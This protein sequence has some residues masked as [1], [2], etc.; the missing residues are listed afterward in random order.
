[1]RRRLKDQNVANPTNLVMHAVPEAG[2]VVLPITKAMVVKVAVSGTDLVLLL[3]D[4]TQHVLR[5]FA[6]R[7]LTQPNLRV[8][9][10]DVAVTAAELFGNVGKVAF[11]QLAAQLSLNATSE[12]L[13]VPVLSPAPRPP[14]QQDD[15]PAPASATAAS[16]ADPSLPA[17]PAPPGLADLQVP[18]TREATFKEDNP[19]ATPQYFTGKFS[20]P[21]SASGPIGV[22]PPPPPPADTISLS[23]SWHN[24]TGQVTG[25]QEG[26][27][28]ITGSGGSERSATDYSSEAQAEREIIMGTAGDDVIVG[29]STAQLGTGFARVLD[30]QLSARAALDVKSLTISGLPT[31]FTVVGATVEGSGWKVTLPAD[32]AATGYRVSLTLQ[33]AVASDGTVFTPSLL[34]LSLAASG[35]MLGK[36]ITGTR[37]I[38]GVLRDVTSSTD[39]EYSLAGKDGIVFPAFGLGDEIYAGA[40]ND[41]VRAGVGHDVVHGD[42]GNDNLDGGAGNDVL[43]GGDGADVL[44]GG[45]GVDTAA[46]ASS[47]AGVAVDLARGTATGGQAEGDTLTS[48]ENLTGSYHADTL[49]GDSAANQLLGAEGDDT[50]EGRGGA[51][52]LDGG[53]GFDRADY[54]ASASAVTINLATGT[55]QG[56][57]AEGDRLVGIESVVGG[58]GNDRLTGDALDNQLQGGAGNDTLEGAA[59]ADA[60]DGGAG[61][62]LAT[63]AGAGAAVVVSLDTGTGTA[64][65]ALG[66]TLQDIENLTGSRF[67]DELTGNALANTLS[68]GQGDDLLEGGAGADTLIG[69]DGR[70]TASY[71]QAAQGVVVSLENPTTNTGDALGDTFQGIENLEG[72]EFD[73]VLTGDAQANWLYGGPGDDMLYGKAGNDL[74]F[75]GVG[76]DTLDGGD[77]N[78]TAVY[79][80]SS[81]AVNANLAQNRGQGGD[82]EGDTYNAV[83]N[84]TGSRYADTLV[85]DAANNTLD[86]GRGNDTLA[87]GAG[88]DVLQG[89]DGSDTADYS[90]S[91]SAVRIDMTAAVY[92]GGD[93]VGDKLESIENITGTAFADRLVGSAGANTLAGGGADDVLEG[94]AG[95]DNLQGG[96]G[97][98]LLLGGQG[99]D[100]L[101][102]GAGSDTASYAGTADGVIADLVTG[103]GR[104]GEAEG[105]AYSGIEN[106]VGSDGDDVLSGTADAN[107]LAGG[108]GNDTLEGGAG[109]DTLDGGEGLDT[110][111][112]ARAGSGIN[113]NLA[114]PAQGNGDATGDRYTSIENLLGSAFADVLRGDA[115]A[116]RLDGA[117]GDDLL[118][119]GAGGDTLVGGEGVDTADYGASAAAVQ[120]D[121]ETTTAQSGGD[122]EGDLLQGLESLLGTRFA[123]TL[124]GDAADN[125]LVG[126]AGN[127]L[128]EGRAGADALE[129]GDGTDTASYAS[130]S[131][132]VTANLAN[133]AQNTGDAAGDTFTDIENLAGGAF[134]DNLTGDASDNRLEGGDGDDTLQGGVGADALLGGLGADTASYAAAAAG[135]VISLAAPDTNTGEAAG[136]TYTSIENLRGSAFD[137]SITGNDSANKLFGGTGADFLIGNGGAD[138]LDGGVGTDTASYAA[139]RSGV[140]VNL[141]TGQGSG[142]DAQG[143]RLINVENL[144]GSAF[145]DTLTGNSL[146]NR[147]EGGEGN[148]VLDGGLGADVLR[149]GL[150]DDTYGVDNDADSVAEAAGEGTDTVRASVSYALGANLED[151]VLVGTDDIDGTGNAVANQLTGN[152]GNNR[153]D[154]GAGADTLAGGAGDDTYVVDST[155]DLTLED[156]GAGTDTVISSITWR[157]G[158]SIENLI[159]TGNADLN[160]TGNVLANSLTGNSGNNRLDGGTGADRMAGGAGD[161][162]YL[163]DNVGD[164]VSELAGEGYDLVR[165]G[166]NHT[167][168]ANVEALELTGTGNFNA[169]GNSGNNAL[170]GNSGNN[171]LDGG[172]GIDRMTGGAGND[173]YVVD[174]ALDLTVEAAGEGTDTVEA[175]R[176]WT[177]GANLENLLLTGTDDLDGTGNALDNQ[178]IGNDG[179]NL[180]DGAAGA[181]SMEGGA[182]NDTY[183]VD[184]TDDLV[185]EDAG[186]GTDTVRTSVS[187]GLTANVENL[188]LAGN[189]AINGT[190]NDANNQITGNAANNRLDGGRGADRLVGGAGDDTYVVD[191]AADVLL[192]LDAEG[193]DTVRTSVS[194]QLGSNFETLVL[195]GNSAI[196]GTGNELGNLLLGNGGNNVL[197]GGLGADSMVGG[198]G[199]DTYVVDNALDSI[200]EAAGEGTDT[201]RT[202]RSYVLGDHLDN[203]VL[204]GTAQVNGNGNAL[205]NVITGNSAAN[206]LDGGEGADVLI[207]GDGDDIYWVDHV[208]DQVVETTSLAGGVDTVNATVSTLLGQNV[209]RLNLLGSDAIDGSGNELNNT[210]VGNASSNVLDGGAGD[211][212]MTG[213]GGDDTY[214]VDSLGDVVTEAVGAGIDTVRTQLSYVLGANFENLELIGSDTANLTGNTLDNVLTGNSANNVIDGLAGAD[215]MVGGAGDDT[216]GVDNVGD[217]V[218]EQFDEG[219]D[220]VRSTVSYGLAA[221]VEN[222]LLLGAV[223]INATGN[224]LN[225][226]LTGN[227]GANV[228]DGGLGADAMVGGR[229]DDTYIVDNLGDQL[230]EAAAEGRDTVR[231]SVSWA[232]GNNFEDLV[233]TGT[234]NIDATGNLAANT[235]TG[236]AGLNTINGGGGADTINAGAGN[237]TIYV[238]DMA[239]NTVDGGAG[240]DTL[241]LNGAG[242]T[243][244]AGLI[245]KAS[246]I[247]VLDFTGGLTDVVEIRAAHVASP[248]LLGAEANGKLEIVLDGPTAG[249]DALIL[250]ASE[251]NN[252]TSVDNAPAVFLS[253]GNAGRLLTAVAPGGI[254]LAIDFGTL[255]LPPPTELTTIWGR[256]ADPS[257]V[258]GISGLA[259]WL[260]ATDLDGDG[261][262]EGLNEAGITSGAGNLAVWADKSGRGNNFTQSADATARPSL[263]T[264]GG[265][266]G[267][268]TVRFDGGDTLL[269]GTTFAQSYTVFVVGAMEGSQNGRLVASTNTNELIGWWGGS[270]NNF[271][272]AGWVTVLQTPIVAGAATMFTATGANGSGYLWNNGNRLPQAYAGVQTNEDLGNLQLGAAFGNN[273]SEASKADLSEVLV[274]DHALTDGERRVVESYLRTKWGVGA[275]TAPTPVGVMGTIALD[276]TWTA[277]KLLY[278][279]TGNDTLNVGYTAAAPRGTGRVDAVVFGGADNDTL[280]GGDRVDALYGGDGN[281]VLNGGLGA[282][283]LAGGAGDDTYTVDSLDDTVVEEAGA[284]TDT[285]NS[286][287]SYALAGNIENLTLTGAANSD[288]TGNNLAN[289]ITGNAGNNRIDGGLGADTMIGGDGNDTYTVDNLGDV[290]IDSSGSDTIRTALPGYVMQAGLENLQLIGTADLS[291]TANAS[292]NWVSVSSYGGKATVYG[293]AGD[294]TYAIGQDFQGLARYDHVFVENPG[295]GNDTVVIYRNNPSTGYVTYTAPSNIE[296][297]NVQSTFYVN[298]VGSAD[299]NVLTGSAYYYTG[300]GNLHSLSGGLGNDAYRVYVP[301][302]QVIENAGEGVDTIEAAV[303]F[304]LAANVENGVA[305]DL[306]NNI[307]NRI[308]LLGNTQNNTLT[309]NWSNNRLNGGLGDDT[310]VGGKGDDTFV[311]DSLGDVISDTLGVDTVETSLANYTLPSAFEKLIFTTAGVGHSGTGNAS[312]NT[313]VGNTANDT[314]LGNDGDDVLIGS[315]AGGDGGT[316]NLAGGNGNDLLIAQNTSLRGALQQGLRA[317]YFNNTSWAGQP[318]LVRFENVNMDTGASPGPGIGADNFSVRFTGDLRAD[319]TGT[320]TFRL[321]SDDYGRVWIDDQLVI[322]NGYGTADSMTIALA[323]GQHKIVVMGYEGGG[324]ASAVLS[325]QTPGSTSFDVVPVTHLSYGDAPSADTGGD[326][327]DGGAGDDW[328][329]GGAAADTL[330]GGAGNDT[331]IVSNTADTLVELA[332]GGTDTV[333]SSASYS[334]AGTQLENLQLT[335]AAAIDGTGSMANNV[336]R[337]NAAANV[338]TGDG[339]ND[340]LMGGGGADTLYGGAGNDTLSASGGSLLDGGDDNDTLSLVSLWTPDALAGKA[341]WLDAA[342]IDGDGI[343][344]GYGEAGLN[345]GNQVQVWRDKSGL[346]RDAIQTDPDTQPLLVM[347]A[348]NGQASVKFDGMG[349]VITALGL[350]TLTGNTN[351]LFWVQNTNKTYYMPMH[352]GA[353]GAGS[354]NLI[355]NNGDGR[356][357]LTG[358]GN[359]H[360]AASFGLDGATA[361]FANAGDAY[362]KLH[363]GTH[364]VSNLNQPFAWNGQLTLAGGYQGTSLDGNDNMLAWNFAGHIPE[365]LVTTQTLGLADQQRVEGYLAWKWG[366]QNFLPASHP[367]KNAA[368]TLAAASGG[369]LLGGNGNDSLT[370]GSGND[371]LDGGAGTDVMAG[372]LGNDTYT[373]DTTADVLVE[374]AGAGTDTVQTA[375]SY[376]LPTHFETLLLTG[377]A[378]LNGTGNGDDNTLTGNTGANLLRGLAGNDLLDGGAG[379]DVLEGGTGDDVYLVDDAGDVVTEQSSEGSDTVRTS[380]TYTL[381]NHFENLVLTGSANLDATGNAADNQI[382]G[383]SGNNAIDGGAGADTLAGGAGNDTYTVDNALDV[384]VE[385]AGEGTDTVISSVSSTLAANVET[386]VLVGAALVGTGNAGNNTLVGNA[387]NNTL[388]GGTGADTLQGGMGDDSYVVDNVSDA[389]SELVG[390][391]TDSVSASV[392]YTLAANVENLTLTGASSFSGSGNALDN[393]ITGNSGNNTLRGFAGNDWLDGGLGSDAMFGGTGDD[394]F[395]V[396]QATDSVT[397]LAGEGLDTVRA[398]ISYTLGSDVENLVLTGTA[399]S[400]GTGNSLANSITGNSAA[401]TLDGGAGA[402]TLAGGAG[403]DIYWVDNVGDVLIEFAAEGTDSV[404]S[405]VSYSL[406]ANFENL[407]LTGGNAINGTGNGLDNTLIGNSADNVLTGGGGQDTLQGGGGNDRL[408][409][410]NEGNL[411]AADGGSGDDWLQFLNSGSSIDLT[412]LLG[413]VQNIESLHL[414]NGSNDLGV[415][416][417]AAAVA[418]LADNR[419]T[420]A[421]RLDSGDTL[422]ISGT[423]QETSRTVAGDGSVQ[424]SYQLWSGTDVLAPPTSWL[425]VVWLPP[426]SPG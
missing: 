239:F 161:D 419:D 137:D 9:F 210:I 306:G 43:E 67:N 179:N 328:L 319:T 157:L 310:L 398:D 148:D 421:L 142:G 417:D 382:T 337:G 56:G 198:G 147:L 189:S 116:N 133:V 174:N 313:L 178:L 293:G 42:A 335:G 372:G 336:L 75:S 18:V 295:E 273:R 243:T 355:V 60:L 68:G 128:L 317:E 246:N 129:G 327:L 407:Q 394:T 286:S 59:G 213:G 27:P 82:A 211:D 104:R 131:G 31:G 309:G 84:I 77:G 283:W 196:N 10:A 65:D 36:D 186:N 260:D 300:N 353:G 233:L 138:T 30:L 415:L 342:D 364:T 251:Y 21:A 377:A 175:S 72:S 386:L 242:L 184:N 83:E 237:D 206:V 102:G 93:A 160:A 194:W 96:D 207:G 326:T 403:N 275:A 322:Y 380:I 315:Q 392:S 222:L 411:V 195:T 55:G 301:A 122:A 369:T 172:V 292:N 348:I 156:D 41:T 40:G 356:T 425:N 418:G 33:Y 130:A 79:S 90:A 115:E 325:W 297:I 49:R 412:G 14:Q 338:L 303:D 218:L 88:A 422:N 16:E 89:G 181:D 120:I 165:A 3:T 44:T 390:E 98:D 86:G 37:V 376:T 171:R 375:I 399:A 401:N 109:A 358:Y 373:V 312:N 362:A 227:Q 304:A 346:G 167:L 193:T 314:L 15:A 395:V 345:L 281:D 224:A 424:A 46:Y 405:S 289:T 400:N 298:A 144:V 219:T 103:K 73:D 32:F 225:N 250:S 339:G 268:P 252:V 177:L 6:L 121:L 169:T 241:F 226:V 416:L 217:R 274:Y 108:K 323:A 154:G 78:D 316:D 332:G 173:T 410:Q 185:A 91:T 12:P 187:Y 47:E 363:N 318:A 54:S 190:G 191:N 61:T 125:R 280:N 150:G 352:T 299:N 385:A 22:P 158:E 230:V 212:T 176:N 25:T 265:M 220:L 278:G 163:V 105:D 272:S 378:D 330:T 71:L 204:T 39:M 146:A 20:E 257:T 391:G 269:S 254:N 341:L 282:D 324:G 38:P 402:D 132:A 118:V 261:I 296:N 136:D 357:D 143:D 149:G 85:G 48:I 393:R 192:E 287:A 182:G 414:S 291:V 99:G 112:Y 343:A 117:D 223:D 23:A 100:V 134:D 57:D 361:N 408:V 384:V 202:A 28:L 214:V 180:L 119:G 106:L 321:K 199:D 294:D 24:V 277:A 159:L 276:R 371:L 145:D 387:N 359:S 409:L 168:A 209:E 11:A 229:G 245:G 285:V 200:L 426:G 367:Y 123:D 1:V 379:A 4:G 267:L 366:N 81:E 307:S 259:T 80:S 188:V 70:D 66:D 279:T 370:G 262:S 221:N 164:V 52:L 139:S 381:G 247:E 151:L 215:T 347:N 127:D 256:V 29:D 111:S 153:L 170:T 406:Q 249:N 62:D 258:T 19:P 389:V 388:D 69:G 8:V 208:A 311:V 423:Y 350:P 383:N 197:D 5:D 374:A 2:G 244:L 235:I 183:V 34:D 253:N 320:Y 305:M 95:N 351:S 101:A 17:L 201:V 162:V 255:V 64:G 302:T 236:N 413:R 126:G 74:L 76:R 329:L 92:E 240:V 308:N 404:N 124:R 166:A 63:Y 45:T 232:L 97:D 50:L 113:A 110:A 360:S 114:N 340:T 354:W 135:V 365:V 231:T 7:M 58:V 344:E 397:E 53:E 263:V 13:A 216:Y 155:G 368:P 271:H 333:Q 87:G 349:D 203:L 234:S 107:V 140:T 141:A 396:N 270:Q 420:L 94:R 152:A 264:T 288:A 35:T 26:K 284:G 334:L 331:Y 290:I 51:D 238:P 266:N 205:D 228:L 248:G